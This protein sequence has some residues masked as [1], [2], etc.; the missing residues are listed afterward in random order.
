MKTKPPR[1]ASS[2]SFNV[3][4]EIKELVSITNASNRLLYVNPALLQR[5]GYTK[6][7]KGKPGFWN[8]DSLPDET[9]ADTPLILENVYSSILHYWFDLRVYYS[10]QENGEPTYIWI[11]IE[12]E[13]RKTRDKSTIIEETLRAESELYHALFKTSPSGILLIDSKGIIIDVNQSICSSTGYKPDELIGKHVSFLALPENIKD[14]KNNIKQILSGKTL[15]HE[16][17]SRRKDNS[18]YHVLLVETAIS[19]PDGRRG[20]L[21]VSND[22]SDRKTAEIALRDS[23]TWFKAIANYTANW[24]SMF[25][26]EGRI[27]WTNP[28][29]ERFTGYTPAEFAAMP[30]VVDVVVCKAERAKARKILKRALLESEGTVNYL[31]CLR[32]DGT[33]FWLSLAWSHIKD[34]N[35]NIIGIR[36][37][38]QD[39]TLRLEAIEELSISENLYRYMIENAPFGMYFFEIN[40]LDELIFTQANPAADRIFNMD[41]SKLLDQKIEDAFPFLLETEAPQRFREAA[42]YNKTWISELFQPGI[43]PDFQIYIEVKAFQTIKNKMAFIFADISKKVLA[44]EQLKESRQLF[45]TLAR[46]AP[47]GIFRTNAAGRTTYVN[48]RWS[49]LSGLS[50]KDALDNKYVAAIHPDDKEARVKEWVYAVKHKIPVVSEY[51]FV[52][53]D[54]SIIWVQGQAIPEV[55]DGQVK[56]YIGTVTDITELIEIQYDLRAAK[57]K[58]EASNRLKTTFMK[59]LS[60]E[61]RT[62][63]NGI[64]GF[65]QLLGSGEYSPEENREFIGF[66]EAS[67]ARM[68]KTIDNTMELSLLMTGN[69]KR[70]DGLFNLETLFQEIYKSFRDEADRKKITFTVLSALPDESMVITDRTMVKRILV[71]ITDNAFKFTEKGKIIIDY[72]LD[73]DIVKI[74]ISDTGPGIAPDYLPLIFEPFMQENVYVA[75][76]QSSAGLGLS[77]VHELISQLGGTIGAVSE[78]GKGTSISLMIPVKRAAKSAFLELDQGGSNALVNKIP[79]ILIVEDEQINM[80]FIRHLLEKFNCRLLIADSGEEAISLV[81][82]NPEIDII[83]M[84]IRMPGMDGFQAIEIIR[85]IKPTIKIAAVTAYGSDSDRQACLAAGCVDYIAKPFQSNDLLSMLRKLINWPPG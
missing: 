50:F 7:F 52:R 77:I 32:K 44:E 6:T 66:L 46:M 49:A 48:P 81:K 4:S 17:S 12:S 74:I 1:Y 30:D 28:A 39:V 56:G 64:F 26:V 21:S 53:P 43:A 60:H 18:V 13:T 83:L 3:F 40:D 82:Q 55:V 23:E 20:I 78:L 41:H 47:V 84:D 16:V 29:A 9:H 62:P 27:V 68:T 75:R 33:S 38:G 51:R 22:V 11:A 8:V 34:E 85:E 79:L 42:L 61:I 15:K 31:R 14:I 19:L 35:N 58:A 36:T 37:S 67:I 59:N 73:D 10:K 24:E 2:V 69:M 5:S 71:E 65:A 70:K 80:L 25:N 45:E 76:A 54:G 63:L 57:E 72:R